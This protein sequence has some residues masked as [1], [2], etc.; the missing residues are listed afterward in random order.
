MLGELDLTD[1]QEVKMAGSRAVRDRLIIGL[2]ALTGLRRRIFQSLRTIGIFRGGT[3]LA[4]LKIEAS[5]NKT[6]V[7]IETVLPDSMSSRVCRYVDHYASDVSWCYFRIKAWGGGRAAAFADDAIYRL[8]KKRLVQL[9]GHDLTLHD[10][11]RIIATSIA[12]KTA[13]VAVTKS[14]PRPCQ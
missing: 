9:T 7:P 5:K 3:G 12:R 8:F 4:N 6:K 11:R 1:G 2:L 14:G 13:N 10:A